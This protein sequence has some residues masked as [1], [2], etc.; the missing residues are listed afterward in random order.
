MS[1]KSKKSFLFAKLILEF[2]CEGHFTYQESFL[3]EHIF[4]ISSQDLCY[5]DL[6][7]YIHT[8]KF[9]QSF[10]KDECWKL[11]NLAKI[12]MVIRDALCHQG[13]D[14]ILRHCLTIEEFDSFLNDCQSGDWNGH[15]SW[16]ATTHKIFCARYFWPS[17]FKD[18]IEVVKKYHPS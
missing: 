13:F 8:S 5:G 6:I 14:S 15:F 1:F 16:L 7:I 4:L 11:H 17:I 3:D 10:S 12:H 9:P 18:Y 2:H